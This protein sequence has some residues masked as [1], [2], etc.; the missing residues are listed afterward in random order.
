MGMD[1]T[2]GPFQRAALLRGG[3]AGLPSALE[4][5]SLGQGTWRMAEREGLRE[6]EIAALRA[7]ID[8][9]VAMI[10][11][12]E[13]YAHGG[14]EALVGE[15]IR[16]LP[17]DGLYIVSKVYPHNAGGMALVRSCDASL[18]RLGV[19]TLD[20]YLLHW[21]GHIPLA[22]TIGGMEALVR[23]GKIRRWGVSNFDTDDLA[24][25]LD[26]PGG[27]RCAANQVLYHLGSRGVEYSLLPLMA[28]HGITPIAYCPLAQAGSLRHGLTDSPIVHAVAEK[29]GISP[30]QALL[31]FVLARP[32]MAAIPKAGTAAH[33][34]Q[35]AAMQRIQLGAE[36]VAALDAA[37]PA[38]AHK[39]PLDIE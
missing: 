22:E 29:H 34:V 26:I 31:G 19:D 20:L 6:A 2:R 38:P 4:M 37:F 10:D 15:A 36:D 1:G 25:L 17:R 11:T 27:A 14:A 21:P 24:A 8:A 33:A 12:A 5:P 32:G 13:M 39:V 35:N 23:A 16:G 9:G 28:A 3:G 18:R 7:G 30:M